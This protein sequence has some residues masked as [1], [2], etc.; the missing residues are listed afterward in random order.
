MNNLNS[1]VVRASLCRLLAALV[2]LLLSS[3]GLAQNYSDIWYNPDESGWGLT[4]ADHE[5]QIFVVWYTYRQDGSPTWFTIPGGTFSQGRRFFSGDVYSTIGPAFGQPFDP[6]R[7]T[8]TKQGTASFDF[9]PEGIAQGVA[10]FTYSLGGVTQT[11][12]I[13]RQGFGNAAPYWGTDATDIW[14]D[15]SQSGWGLTLSQHGNNVFGVWFTYDAQGRP[16]FVVMPGVTFTGDSSFTGALYTT[17]GPSFTESTFNPAL[18]KVTAVGSANVTLNLQSGVPVSGSFAAAVNGLSQTKSLA[19]Q[20]FGNAAPVKVDPVVLAQWERQMHDKGRQN[21]D[22]ITS[23]SADATSSLDNR[24][25]AV[26]YDGIKVYSQIGDYTRLTDPASQ[27]YWLACQKTAVH[28]YRDQY[29]FE[30]GCYGG[31]F[32]CVPGYEN[33]TTGL[34][35]DYQKTGDSASRQAAIDLSENAAYAGDATD[36]TYTVSAEKSR[37]VAY[38]IRSYVDAELLGEP[39]RARL[40]DLVNQA[41]GHID[42]WFISKSYRC[43]ATCDPIDAAGKYYI[44]PFMVGLTSEALIRYHGRTGDVRVLPAIRTALDAIW[45]LAWQ[46]GDGS[47]W[48]D[49][50]VADPSIA[51][52]AKSGSPD[53]DL[54]IAPA[55]AWLYTQTGDTKYRDRGDQIFA[56][57]VAKAY[58]DGGKQFDQNY[59]WSFDYLTWRR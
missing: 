8:A 52:P 53:L 58:L 57:G 29:V 48:Y 12:R 22:A 19:R 38:A 28:I 35:F 7:V 42:Q 1:F 39:R 34:R 45:N 23:M 49:N 3:S 18:V 20:P 14:W 44:Q 16:L 50:W 5:T 10:L 17:T 32:G 6:S 4:I 31:V 56:G 36:L 37:E 33:F 26:Y 46:S 13:Q 9:A 51:F 2:T 41:L 54:L 24:L 55:F 30:P 11:K 43:S 40:A 59:M 27:A 15:P 47:F 21:C 25:S